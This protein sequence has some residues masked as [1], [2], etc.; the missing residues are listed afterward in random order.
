MNFIVWFKRAIQTS[1]LPSFDEFYNSWGDDLLHEQL[2]CRYLID[3][4]ME[5]VKFFGKN[6][7]DVTLADGV[8]QEIKQ[9][10]KVK[11]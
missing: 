11:A 8:I 7:D 9:H 6:Y 4:N 2:H 10:K 1:P 5:F 3:P